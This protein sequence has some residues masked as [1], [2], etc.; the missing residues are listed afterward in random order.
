MVAGRP[1]LLEIEEAD[2]LRSIP[3]VRTVIPRV[4][5][6]R[7]LPSI[8][9]NLTIVG[10]NTSDGDDVAVSEGRL[11]RTGQEIAIGSALAQA[12]ALRIGDEFALV[13]DGQL[14]FSTVVG[15]CD[16]SSAI[17]SADLAAGLVSGA[18]SAALRK[19]K[20]PFTSKHCRTCLASSNVN[21][22]LF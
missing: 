22:L 9:G 11:P 21:Q 3:A 7:F 6:Y 8:R 12:L 5:G 19:A 20:F 13:S 16:E 17:R 1:A 15:L 2:E 4:W 14:I 18:P 10:V